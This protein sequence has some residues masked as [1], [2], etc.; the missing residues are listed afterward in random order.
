MLYKKRTKNKGLRALKTASGFQEH[1]NIPPHPPHLD[2]DQTA[3]IVRQAGGESHLGRVFVVVGPGS[4]PTAPGRL[5]MHLI[6]CDT[7]N[8]ANDAV[9][10]ATGRATVRR[11]K[12]P[13]MPSDALQATPS[14]RNDPCQ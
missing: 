12:S 4:Y 14:P 6:E 9:N 3:E 10:V 2:H 13:K 1:G 5:V 7:I 11:V 8:R